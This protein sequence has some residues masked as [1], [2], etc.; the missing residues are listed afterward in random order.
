MKIL[1]LIA[2]WQRL[3][4]TELVYKHLKKVLPDNV[5][6]L[7]VGSEPDHKKLATKYKFQYCEYENKLG[8][9]L[10]YAL[11]VAL[12]SEWDY[13]MQIGS[14]DII[15]PDLFQEYKKYYG[16]PV[17]GI[18]KC[19]MHEHATGETKLFSYN[20]EA[21]LG[22]G[23]MISRHAIEQSS[24]CFE[25][26]PF[27]QLSDGTNNYH[28]NRVAKVPASIAKSWVKSGH[29]E[30]VNESITVQLWDPNAMRSMDSYSQKQLTL[31]GFNFTVMET[32]KVL[33][34]DIKSEVNIVKFETLSMP[35]VELPKY[36]SDSIKRQ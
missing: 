31:H 24:I 35:S 17:F 30:M 6:V 15:H 13:L 34:C 11:S 33:L 22:A 20:R 1:L 19:Y 8:A 23:R 16:L 26:K 32:E 7:I 2:V 27:I 25:V 10:N 4:I 21:I 28:R 9:K 14:D 12:K 3:D 5:D 18:D 36:Y 29:A